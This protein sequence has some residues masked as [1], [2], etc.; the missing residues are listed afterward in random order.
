MSLYEKIYSKKNTKEIVLEKSDEWIKE[1]KNKEEC[2]EQ[3]MALAHI[4]FMKELYVF[5]CTNAEKSCEYFDKIPDE[6][7]DMDLLQERI[8]ALKLCYR[9]ESFVTLS[10]DILN[11]ES[12]F[13]IRYLIL[14]ELVDYSIVAD[15]I[16][17]QEE[18]FK[19]KMELKD[20]LNNEYNSVEKIIP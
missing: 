5:D 6:Y 18:Y 12:V 2:V 13:G 4:Y 14:K 17:T 16:I 7:Y 9:F 8:N 3:Y 10:K 19:Y 20:L 15:G 1:L 11:R